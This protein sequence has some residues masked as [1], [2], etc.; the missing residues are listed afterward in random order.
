MFDIIILQVN[1]IPSGMGVW[2]PFLPPRNMG[3]QVSRSSASSED[4]GR[5]GPMLLWWHG[6]GA[7]RARTQQLA[8]ARFTRGLLLSRS[9]SEFWVRETKS[10]HDATSACLLYLSPG[11][12]GLP[13]RY[14]CVHVG[15]WALLSAFQLRSW[16]SPECAMQQHTDIWGCPCPAIYSTWRKGIRWRCKMWPN[17]GYEVELGVPN[18]MGYHLRLGTYDRNAWG[19]QCGQLKINLWPLPGWV[20]SH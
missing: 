9:T 17:Y 19:R 2:L 3:A 20:T 16:Q 8:W 6:L 7:E 4:R 14:H 5:T 1:V 18:P 11:M 12:C 15:T 10:C 13:G